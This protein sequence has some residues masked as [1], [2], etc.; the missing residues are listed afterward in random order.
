MHDLYKETHKNVYFVIIEKNGCIYNAQLYLYL[1]I[2]T[3]HP[4]PELILFKMF[5]TKTSIQ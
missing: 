4:T 1:T 5:S 3:Y 2:F